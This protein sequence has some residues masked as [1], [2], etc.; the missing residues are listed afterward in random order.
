MLSTVSRF[1]FGIDIDGLRSVLSS[2][3]DTG[4][5]SGRPCASHQTE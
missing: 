4:Q 3:S 5:P 1:T 2:S